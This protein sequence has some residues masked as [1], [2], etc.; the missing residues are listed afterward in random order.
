MYVYKTLQDLKNT[1]E[2]FWMN[3]TFQT[4]SSQVENRLMVHEST[5]EYKLKYIHYLQYSKRMRFLI[6]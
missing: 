2:C 3:E 1:N 5:L 4:I 6:L